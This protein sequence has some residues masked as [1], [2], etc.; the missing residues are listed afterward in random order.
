ML[1]V[2]LIWKFAALLRVVVALWRELGW[3]P[4]AYL[5]FKRRGSTRFPLLPTI[6]PASNINK[7]PP[8]NEAVL[9]TTSSFLL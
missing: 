4:T 3:R 2:G 5:V 7:L 8:R 6:P 9:S 1:K